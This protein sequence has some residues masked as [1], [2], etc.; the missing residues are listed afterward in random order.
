MALVNKPQC[1]D[2][3]VT[4]LRAWHL[5]TRCTHLEVLDVRGREVRR[6]A[7]PAGVL[8]LGVVDAVRQAEPDETHL[9]PRAA[10]G[11]GLVPLGELQQRPAQLRHVGEPRGEVGRVLAD[12]L[13]EERGGAALPQKFEG[14][15]GPVLR[16]EAA[17]VGDL[18]LEV[19]PSL[20]PLDHAALGQR[21]VAGREPDLERR[22][23]PPLP[24]PP[25]NLGPLDLP[26]RERVGRPGDG[27]VRQPDRGVG[28]GGQFVVLRPFF[29]VFG[30]GIL[31]LPFLVF[32]S[33]FGGRPTAALAARGRRLDRAAA[34]AAGVRRGEGDGNPKVGANDEGGRE[35]EEAPP[36]P[37]SRGRGRPGGVTPASGRRRGSSGVV[38]AARGSPRHRHRYRHDYYFLCLCLFVGCG[39]WVKHVPRFFSADCEKRTV[40]MSPLF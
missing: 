26:A 40:Q 36:R 23:L 19:L 14:A 22:L 34:A 10:G 3:G 15:A 24:Q 12:V 35:E 31:V 33:L 27:A 11:R 7:L 2:H 9:V 39:L 5:F 25:D 1:V 37:G 17:Q 18:V 4:E 30:F 16:P 20:A 29:F 28:D 8:R 21:V 38:G 13:L 32:R 6:E